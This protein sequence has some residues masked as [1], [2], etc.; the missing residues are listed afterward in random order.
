MQPVNGTCSGG[1]RRLVPAPKAKVSRGAGFCWRA[2]CR[3][4]PCRSCWPSRHTAGAAARAH[5][6]AAGPRDAGPL[7]EGNV[8]RRSAATEMRTS[9]RADARPAPIHCC[10]EGDRPSSAPGG[11]RGW[12]W[13]IATG[14]RGFGAAAGTHGAAPGAM[15]A[16]AKLAPWRNGPRRAFSLIKWQIPGDNFLRGTRSLWCSAD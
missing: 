7:H 8:R 1:G 15:Q 9:H 14:A 4:E 5:I 10:A 3:T 16:A 2:E 13:A 12:W 6:P 11:H